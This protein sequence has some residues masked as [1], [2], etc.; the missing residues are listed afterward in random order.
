MPISGL[1]NGPSHIRPQASRDSPGMGGRDQSM[2]VVAINRNLWSRSSGARTDVFVATGRK[3]TVR[4]SR[5][6]GSPLT[7]IARR[8][9][10]ISGRLR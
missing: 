2:Q 10:A 5:T 7:N 6:H 1:P 9:G 8:V 4:A 3:N